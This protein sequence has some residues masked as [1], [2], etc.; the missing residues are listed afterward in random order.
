VKSRE[1]LEGAVRFFGNSF[2][3]LAEMIG[4]RALTTAWNSQQDRKDAISRW[5][6]SIY[7]GEGHNVSWASSCLEAVE[8]GL[9]CLSTQLTRG[10]LKTAYGAQLKNPDEWPQVIYEIRLG[11][12]L[13][14]CG[15]RVAPHVFLEDS[16][17]NYDLRADFCGHTVNVE[18]KA[19]F[20]DFPRAIADGYMRTLAGDAGIPCGVGILFDN[21]PG[22]GSIGPL[23]RL[24]REL[25]HAF[26]KRQGSAQQCIQGKVYRKV[27]EVIQFP[28]GEAI[29]C[30]VFHEELKPGESFGIT[31]DIRYS[32]DPASEGMEQ[33]PNI[34]LPLSVKL[35]EV[36]AAASLQ[37]PTSGINVVAL[38][39]E[40]EGFAKDVFCAVYGDTELRRRNGEW[41]TIFT[42]S[43]ISICGMWERVRQRISHVL[44]VVL[45][46]PWD[47]PILNLCPIDP[48]LA[49]LAGKIGSGLGAK[50]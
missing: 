48:V 25:Y 33:Q 28:V 9:R 43:G 6:A 45:P 24:I 4:S 10:A 50:T 36:V 13:V 29:D 49:M 20:D 47:E 19:I 15:A 38:V 42:P 34:R 1:Q 40:N 12:H 37:L 2:P 5:L 3:L 46:N 27:D 18:V 31:G 26:S 11:A 32:S 39:G 35:R 7:N 30:I 41:T 21:V 8:K 23:S 14:N 17:R 44:G 22:A 16:S